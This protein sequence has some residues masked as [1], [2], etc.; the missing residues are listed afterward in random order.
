V[1]EKGVLTDEAV[2]AVATE[3]GDGGNDSKVRED[4]PSSDPELHT[5]SMDIRLGLTGDEKQE[6]E[7]SLVVAEVAHMIRGGGRRSCPMMMNPEANRALWGE[8]HLC[9]RN[10]PMAKQNGS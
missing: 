2:G 5:S 9:K 10:R 1:A 8:D 7:L 4:V 6:N 3:C